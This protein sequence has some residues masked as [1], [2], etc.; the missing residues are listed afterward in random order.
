[1]ENI[2]LAVFLADVGVAIFRL[3]PFIEM[4]PKMGDSLRKTAKFRHTPAMLCHN[5]AM[6]DFAI[7][8]LRLAMAMFLSSGAMLRSSGTMFL[9]RGAMFAP[10]P[11]SPKYLRYLGEVTEGRR[12]LVGWV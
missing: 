12:G 1:G 4:I 3:P 7:A 11:T 8:M 2:R 6:L 10:T 5:M 9:S